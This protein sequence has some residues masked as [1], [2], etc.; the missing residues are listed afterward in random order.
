MSNLT[1]INVLAKKNDAMYYTPIEK[2]Q[3]MWVGPHEPPSGNHIQPSLH[4]GVFP[5]PR[6]TTTEN[7]PRPKHFTDIEVMWDVDCELHIDYGY[8]T[9]NLSHYDKPYL[10]PYESATYTN[11]IPTGSDASKIY[12]QNQFSTVAGMYPA[13]KAKS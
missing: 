6:L 5:V 9:M 4:V 12:M 11:T 10:V 8:G 1:N 2:S 3:Y 7:E 13:R